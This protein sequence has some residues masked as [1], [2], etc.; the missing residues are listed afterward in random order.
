MVHDVVAKAL[1]DDDEPGPAD[2][3]LLEEW[4]WDRVSSKVSNFVRSYE[5]RK[6]SRNYEPGKQHPIY[7]DGDAV[8][9]D[10]RTAMREVANLEM[11][12]I[13]DDVV[14][15][16]A[17]FVADD[18]QVAALLECLRADIRKREEI[19]QYLEVTPTEITN[20]GKRL[21]RR[22]EQFA[23]KNVESNPFKD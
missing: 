1:S 11:E 10:E 21:K 18:S 22:T 9:R 3:V 15:R 13:A 23:A 5:N 2:G 20:I 6:R 19:A 14:A 12:A 17:R 7:D 4:L 8:S 16:F